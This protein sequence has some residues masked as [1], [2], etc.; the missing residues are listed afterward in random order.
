M[1]V[2][3]TI[4]AIVAPSLSRSMR[5]HVMNEQATRLLA[6][7][8]YSR[9]EAASQ[10]IPIVGGIDPDTRHFGVDVKAGYTDPALRTK[11]YTLPADL[12]F[13]PPEGAQAS[14]TAGHGFDVAEFAPDGTLDPSSATA[15][16]IVNHQANSGAGIKQTADGYGYEINQETSR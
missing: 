9:D 7:T 10:G 3:V 14:K 2:L 11:E 15:V 16:R 4:L 6:L 1:A 8:E 5:A 12:S 13:D